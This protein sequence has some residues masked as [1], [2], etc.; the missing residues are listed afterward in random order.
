MAVVEAE[1]RGTAFVDTFQPTL[2][3]CGVSAKLE[4]DRKQQLQILTLS[5]NA[6]DMEKLPA[7]AEELLGGPG[8]PVDPPAPGLFVFVRS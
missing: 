6:F 2:L 5:P 3:E 1:N 7:V 4:F 8:S